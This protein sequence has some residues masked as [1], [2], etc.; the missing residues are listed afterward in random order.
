MWIWVDMHECKGAEEEIHDDFL[1][2]KFQWIG[3]QNSLLL[4]IFC[5]MIAIPF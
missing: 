3:Q 5:L 2:Y 1:V 4:E